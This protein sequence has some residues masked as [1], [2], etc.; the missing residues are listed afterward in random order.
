[1]QDLAEETGTPTDHMKWDC[2]G[3]VPKGYSVNYYKRLLEYVRT[4]FAG[5]YW[6]GL[7]RD[8]AQKYGEWTTGFKSRTDSTPMQLRPTPNKIFVSEKLNNRVCVL[9][10][11]FFPSDSR[12]YKEV[13]ALVEAGFSVDVICLRGLNQRPGETMGAV[14]IIR[15]FHAKL[16]G[17]LI[18]YLLEYGLSIL[19][20]FVQVSL[21][22]LRYRYA[23][24]QVNTMPDSLVFATIVARLL[25]ARILLDMH[26]PM[27]ELFVTKYGED[28]MHLQVRLLAKIEQLAIEYAHYVITVNET[29][30]Q[31]FIMRGANGGK[32]GVVRNVPVEEYFNRALPSVKREGFTLATHGTIQPRY[33]HDLIIRALPLLRGQ[34]PELRVLFIGSGETVEELQRLSEELA[35][36]DLI[37]FVGQLPPSEVA[38]ALSSVD[39]GL[40]TLM[41]SPF[42]ELCQPNK[43]FEYVAL[44]I[45]VIASRVRAIEESFDDSCIAFYEA[46]NRDTLARCIMDLYSH[47]AKRRRLAATAY[48]RYES[49]RWRVAKN[50]YVRFVRRAICG[51]TEHIQGYE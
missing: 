7:P 2:G 4:A 8:L 34:I 22:S 16:R 9:R 35:C 42:S 38:C 49:L 21:R 30:R 31:R 24:I 44:K 40:V 27:P 33:G 47:P 17:S 37:T 11:G 14:R 6:H 39:I 25:G 26:E 19:Q 46:G 48:E 32:I 45:P 23:C 15:L 50:E 51:G 10:H 29:I 20:M 28:R 43:L 12:V 5:N 41:P 13:D 1:M 18:G 36:A 3:M